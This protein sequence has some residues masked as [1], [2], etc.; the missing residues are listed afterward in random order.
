M[1]L[2]LQQARLEKTRQKLSQHFYRAIL[3]PTG[4]LRAEFIYSGTKFLL[5]NFKRGSNC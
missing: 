1:P 2:T 3:L 4:Q 5:E